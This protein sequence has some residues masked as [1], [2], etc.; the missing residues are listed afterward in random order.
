M[1]LIV[2]P[3]YNRANLLKRCLSKIQ[4]Q[5]FCDYQ[6][7][8]LDD[9]SNDNTKEIANQFLTDYR[10]KYYRFEVNNGH[11]DK[12]L[13]RAIEL[14]FLENKEW[15]IVVAD[16]E[17][18]YTTDHLAKVFD[19]IKRFDD[20]NLVAVEQGYDY[21]NIALVDDNKPQLP[22]CFTYDMLSMEQKNELRKTIR[23]IFKRDL[24]V[25][26]GF[27]DSAKQG[28]SDVVFEG[29]GAYLNIYSQAKIAFV[30]NAVH[31]FGIAPSARR[32]Y[33]D[34]YAW[35]VSVGMTAYQAD[36]QEVF[37]DLLKMHYSPS[38][39]IFLNAFF[40]WG[41]EALALVLK[42]FYQHAEFMRILRQFA[43]IYKNAFGDKF[44][45]LYKAFNEKLPTVD[46]RDLL[47]EKA[48]NIVLYPENSWREQI[49]K[50]LKKR[51][52]NILYVADDFKSG[53]KRYED[54]IKDK[55]KIDCV[56]ITSGHPKIVYNLFA[57]L[58]EQGIK[59]TTL[60]LKDEK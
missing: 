41:G 42:N 55:D 5:T 8:I 49:E 6:V 35:I 45:E 30:S 1:F 37:Y 39:P 15:I 22:L 46:T 3:T 40:E 28:A 16:D 34:F 9:C 57:K 36:K 32:K 43:E 51:G 47:I 56:F 20:V 53:Y 2:I 60:I 50:Y 23:N 19:S 29:E 59:A 4:S 10:F 17:Y 48:D 58:E 13:M 44:L 25:Q 21:G 7:L 11:S 12:V 24:I 26:T 38:Y 18:F 52:K 27:F 14:G 31:V 54:I 33:L